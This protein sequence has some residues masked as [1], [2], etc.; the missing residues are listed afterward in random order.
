[1]PSKVAI[2]PDKPSLGRI[3]A[4]YIAPP[5]SLNSIKR[6]ISRVEGN[7]AFSYVDLFADTTY[8]TPLK[9]GR[10]SILRT[11]GPVLPVNPNGRMAIVQVRNSLLPDGQYFI[12]NRASGTYWSAGNKPIK[13]VYFWPP[14]IVHEADLKKQSFFQVNELSYY[15]SVQRIT[16]FQSGTSQMMLMVTSL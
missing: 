13:T 2:D 14:T 7:P 5:L 1:M 12:K 15:S 4:D 11:D 6:C 10:I 16:L 3:R 9:D 8:D